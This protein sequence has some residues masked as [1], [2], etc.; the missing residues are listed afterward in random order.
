M[1]DGSSDEYESLAGTYLMINEGEK[2]KD[3]TLKFSVVAD[4]YEI[5]Y[6]SVSLW[7]HVNSLKLI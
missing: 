3:F 5:I 7:L 6:H 4:V 1:M 2:Y